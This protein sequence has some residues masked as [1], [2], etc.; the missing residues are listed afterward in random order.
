[1]SAQSPSAQ[2]HREFCDLLYERLLA[3]DTLPEEILGMAKQHLR[4]SPRKGFY[5][6]QVYLDSA[7]TKPADVTTVG[8]YGDSKEWVVV[9]NDA[10]IPGDLVRVLAGPLTLPEPAEGPG[11]RP[12]ASGASQG[13]SKGLPGAEPPDLIHHLINGYVVQRYNVRTGELVDQEFIRENGAGDYD[14]WETPDGDSIDPDDED[15]QER[16]GHLDE[17]ELQPAEM[18]QRYEEI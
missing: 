9:G 14:G 11:S 18:Q 1:M 15:D 10:S 5:F 2:Q 3:G 12:E 6:V 13:P 17:Y 8:W 16:Y 4:P 7:W